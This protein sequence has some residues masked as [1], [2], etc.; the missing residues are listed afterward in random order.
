VDAT[1]ARLRDGDIDQSPTQLFKE[2]FLDEIQVY[3]DEF[4]SCTV[5]LVPSVRDIMSEHASYPQSELQVPF[6]ID[7]VSYTYPT[8]YRE[9]ET[10]VIHVENPSVVKPLP[11]LDQRPC[12][13]C[14]NYRCP[15]S[16]QERGVPFG[17]RSD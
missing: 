6:S 15:I 2:Q 8:C 16:S 17:W 11:I 9:R 12:V 7:A 1:H 14:H 10:E 5:I 4:P 13:C 3:L